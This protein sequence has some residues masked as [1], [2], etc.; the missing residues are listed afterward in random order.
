MRYNEQSVATPKTNYL[1]G[2]V[3][4]GER[5]RADSSEALAHSAIRAGPQR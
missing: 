4:S 5:Q 1:S 3:L 2:Q